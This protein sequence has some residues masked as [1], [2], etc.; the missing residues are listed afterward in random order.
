MAHTL[1]KDGQRLQVEPK[2]FAVLLLMLLRRRPGEVVCRDELM[3]AVWGHRHVTPG[4]LTRVIAQLRHALDDAA[5]EPRYI[6]T[7]HALG[8]CF[9]GELLHFDE[10]EP[11]REEEPGPDLKPAATAAR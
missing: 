2:A 6:Q 11:K 5:H 1:H 3:D 9:V 8:Y 7:M 10:H 4:V